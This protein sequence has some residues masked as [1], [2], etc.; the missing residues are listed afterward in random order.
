METKTNEELFAIYADSLARSADMID[1][2]DIEIAS[3][4]DNIIEFEEA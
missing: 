3:L 1:D 4:K 2:G